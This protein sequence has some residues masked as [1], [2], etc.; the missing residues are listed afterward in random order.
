M[1]CSL[2]RAAL[3]VVAIRCSGLGHA[4]SAVLPLE[5]P[6]R[7]GELEKLSALCLR[8]HG[9][10]CGRVVFRLEV[11]AVVLLVQSERRLHRISE[12]LWPGGVTVR[13]CSRRLDFGVWH[14][15][16][17]RSYTETY[18]RATC[19]GQTIHLR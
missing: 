12:S 2:K 8:A 11:E 14:S 7:P 17:A 13:L 4:A 1:N 15:A 10:M 9:V 18:G 16:A 3:L 19:L 6:E 5:I